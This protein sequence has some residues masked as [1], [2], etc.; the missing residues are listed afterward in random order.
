MN[1]TEK[2]IKRKTKKALINEIKIA[3][4]SDSANESLART[5]IAAFASQL[6]PC[7][8]QLADLR[9][10]VSEA[11]TNCIVHAYKEKKGKIYINARMYSDRTVSVRITDKGCGI[12]DVERAM[13]P[14]FTTGSTEERCGM[15]F[16]V[17]ESFTD[18]VSVSSAVGKGTSVFMTK[19]FE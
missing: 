2:K 10:A 11:V 16:S 9:C 18:G 5:C 12:P 15:G 14:L 17:M 13:Q 3:L 19:K 8:D 1:Q 7:I 6:D 4:N